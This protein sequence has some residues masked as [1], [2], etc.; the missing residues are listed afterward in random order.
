M[1]TVTTGATSEPDLR[2]FSPAAR[3]AVALAEREA[4]S[5]GHE[6]VGTE[7]LLLGLLAAEDGIVDGALRAEGA[8]LT[9]VRRKVVEA[10]GQGAAGGAAP[11]WTPRA[12][13]ALGRAPRFARDR[14]EDLVTPDHV[15]LA[16]LDVEGTAGQVLRGLGVDLEA[17]RSGLHGSNSEV[18]PA[19]AAPKPSAVPPHCPTCH[20]P[21]GGGLQGNEVPLRGPAERRMVVVVS[22][23]G[24]GTILGIV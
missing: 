14:R 8:T 18:E 3:R 19:P 11:R 21:A 5:L 23:P 24:C 6:R 13:R 10:V 12:G 20:E 2:G 1:G 17:L 9:A 15:L 16:V 4:R 22:C 7:H